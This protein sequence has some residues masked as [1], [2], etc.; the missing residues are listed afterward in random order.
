LPNNNNNT[1]VIKMFIFPVETETEIEKFM[2]S[3]SAKTDEILEYDFKKCSK[4]T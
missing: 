3:L 2:G 4:S 1:S